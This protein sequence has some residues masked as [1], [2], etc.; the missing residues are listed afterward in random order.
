[1]D[2]AENTIPDFRQFSDADLKKFQR[3]TISICAF[4]ESGIRSGFVSPK[5][6]AVAEKSKKFLTAIEAEYFSRHPE[7]KNARI[8]QF[9]HFCETVFDGKN[10]DDFGKDA[11]A[12]AQQYF[13]E[14]DNPA[15][16]QKLVTCR[17]IFL[18]SDGT[19]RVDQ[20]HATYNMTT[21]DVLFADLENAM[22]EYAETLPDVP[23]VTTAPDNDG[24]RKEK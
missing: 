7:A 14:Y 22:D 12:A 11:A 9:L 8:Q 15:P 2:N 5:F 19:E 1:M 3:Q 24:A 4:T 6:L 13:V 17:K 21:V 18:E 20:T 16:G 23:T 10:F